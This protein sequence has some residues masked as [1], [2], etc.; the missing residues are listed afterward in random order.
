MQSCI[1]RRLFL[2]LWNRQIQ[3]ANL[4]LTKMPVLPHNQANA[5]F[6]TPIRRNLDSVDSNVWMHA[7]LSS[8]IVGLGA[9]MSL[10]AGGQATESSPARICESRAPPPQ[11]QANV[12]EGRVG[13]MKH[14]THV[15]ITQF[16]LKGIVNTQG[17]RQRQQQGPRRQWP[18]AALLEVAMSKKCT[19]LWRQA[20]SQQLQVLSGF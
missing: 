17:A 12:A 4:N 8:K 1:T 15:Y 13:T 7:T 3:N 11:Q 18:Q 10:D 19:P 5:H 2:S 14:I 16:H 6:E 9:K 20:R